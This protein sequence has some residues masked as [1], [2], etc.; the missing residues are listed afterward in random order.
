MCGCVSQM[1]QKKKKT[2]PISVFFLYLC[3]GLTR[4]ADD[5][6]DGGHRDGRR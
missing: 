5:G 2:H 4:R 6:P 1:L 3:I